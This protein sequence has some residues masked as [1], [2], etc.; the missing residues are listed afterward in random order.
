M[1]TKTLMIAFFFL[2]FI[3]KANGQVATTLNYGIWQTY[4]DSSVSSIP[5]VRG[6][7]LNFKWKDIETSNNVW[8]W[9]NFDKSLKKKATGLPAMLMIFT[10]E[11]S[12]DWLYTSAGVP[13]VIE[14]NSNG[15]SV[16]FAPYFPDSLYKFYFKRMID[17]VANHIA[18]YPVSVRNSIVGIQNCMGEEG[19]YIGY[20]GEDRVGEDPSLIL[21]TG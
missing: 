1:K 8:N 3:I 7:L 17:S 12:P 10:K 4:G 9:T 6:R 19:D 2:V 11:N 15:D 21:N 14:K 16:G 13:K 18:V 20:R 5:Q